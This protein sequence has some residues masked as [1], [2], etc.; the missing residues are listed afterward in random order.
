MNVPSMISTKDLSYIKDM[1]NW[2]IVALKKF[3]V[4]SE[5]ISDLDIMN[6]VN[7]LI[8]LHEENAKELLDVLG[9]EINE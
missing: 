9:S 2:N 8:T 6:I 4:Y 1:F 7:K 5:Y 3:N